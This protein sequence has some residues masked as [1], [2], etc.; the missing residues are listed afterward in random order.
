[1]KGEGQ[2]EGGNVLSSPGG[3]QQP[4]HEEEPCEASP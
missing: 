3:Q 1:M 4:M 2:G